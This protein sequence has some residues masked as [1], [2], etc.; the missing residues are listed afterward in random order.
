MTRIVAIACAWHGCFASNS[1]AN[2][3]RGEQQ[4]NI[5]WGLIQAC[6]TTHVNPRQG[7]LLIYDIVCQYIIYLSDCIR[8]L[9]CLDLV[10]DAAIG[11]FHVHG[12]QDSCFFAMQ[13]L[14]FQVPQWLQVKS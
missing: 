14:S 12:H 1:V 11:L 10:I 5:D 2:L 6:Q 8:H 9:L 13:H 3:F 7:L 4:K